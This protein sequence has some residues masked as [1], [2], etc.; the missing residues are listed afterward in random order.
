MLLDGY[1][2]PGAPC[3]LNYGAGVIFQPLSF[4]AWDRFNAIIRSR[5][6]SPKKV[7]ILAAGLIVKPG[8]DNEQIDVAPVI[9][10]ARNLRT[11]HY[12]EFQRHTLILQG[13]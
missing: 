6:K 11:E 4:T 1:S 3:Y 13:A 9:R 10:I 12:P 8:G 2:F 7:Y 5:R